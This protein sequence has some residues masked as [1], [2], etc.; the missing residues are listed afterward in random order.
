MSE[1]EIPPEAMKLHEEARAA[2][3]SGDLQNSIALLEEAH[4]LAP[5]WPYPLY[6]L[7][8][9]YLLRQDFKSAL[10]YYRATDEIDPAGFFTAKTAIWSLEKEES[11]E[12]VSGL[13]LA[14]VQLEW[15]DNLE[16]KLDLSRKIVARFPTFAPAWKEISVHLKTDE[17]RLETIEHALTLN[18][19][20]ETL[21][22]L[23]LNQALIYQRKGET[24]RA[25][26]IVEALL[27]GE[28]TTRANRSIGEKVLE[29]M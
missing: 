11:G 1:Y 17:E 25:R 18:P 19:D 6:D 24:S 3:Q 20:P 8:F 22:V 9:T 29:Q 28:D 7:A 21:G 5:D 16:E 4:E 26:D 2:G 10:K 27:K 13:Y 15:V 12:F 23:L 14:Y